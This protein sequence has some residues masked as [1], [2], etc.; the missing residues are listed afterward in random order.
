MMVTHGAIAALI[1]IDGHGVH[2]V[3]MLSSIIAL[4]ALRM[5]RQWL[6]SRQAVFIE[7]QC[8]ESACKCLI[9]TARSTERTICSAVIIAGWVRCPVKTDRMVASLLILGYDATAS[10]SIPSPLNPPFQAYS[11]TFLQMLPTVAL[12]S[13]SGLTTWIPRTVYFTSEHIRFYFSVF[14]LYTF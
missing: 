9:I 13:S 14:L 2:V 4:I 8:G 6:Y 1:L 12:L 10:S 11:L 7:R 3:L 5:R